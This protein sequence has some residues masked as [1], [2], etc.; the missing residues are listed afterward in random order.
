MIIGD[1]DL[2]Q[3]IQSI[4]KRSMF[5]T[6]YDID[7]I[8]VSLKDIPFF[9]DLHKQIGE[10]QYQQILKELQYECHLPFEP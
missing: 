2:Y 10:T 5:K 7:F 6:K 9:H 4:N 1:S 8:E 3:L